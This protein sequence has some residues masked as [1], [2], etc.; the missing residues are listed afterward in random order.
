MT[1]GWHGLQPYVIVGRSSLLNLRAQYST[2][3]ITAPILSHPDCTSSLIQFL[4][5]VTYIHVPDVRDH[6]YTRQRKLAMPRGTKHS[7]IRVCLLI[8]I[9]AQSKLA[10]LAL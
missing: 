8:Y 1:R 4:R 9:A 2:Y 7:S 10:V 3:F 6:A 5:K